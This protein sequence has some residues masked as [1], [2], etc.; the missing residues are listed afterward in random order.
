LSHPTGGVRWHV[1]LAGVFVFALA[2]RV[3]LAAIPLERDEGAYAYIAQHWLHGAIPY[4]DAFDHKPPGVLAAYAAILAPFGGNA[5]ASTIHWATQLYSLLTLWLIFWVGRRLA[6]E[7]VGVVAA[8]FAAAMLADQSVFGNAT[9]SEILLILPQTAALAAVLVARDRPAPAWALAA[10]AG[11]GAAIL[12]KQTAAVVA[13]AAFGLVV[14]VGPRRLTRG[15]LFAFG[16]AAP[17]V[18]AIAYFAA[19][20]ALRDLYDGTIGYNRAYASALSARAY[21]VYFSG[22]ARSV[23]MSF[24]PAAAL[25]LG[26]LVR[27]REPATAT[28][29]GS[30]VVFVWLLFSFFAICIGGRFYPHYWIAALPALALL[31]A[32]GLNAVVYAVPA[33]AATAVWIAGILLVPATAIARGPWYYDPRTSADVKARG[34]YGFN[35]FP[36]SPGVAEF[37][38]QRSGPED[39][40]FILGS[41]PQILYA[42]QRRS[43]SRYIYVYPMTESPGTEDLQSRVLEEVA[44][45]RPR[46]IVTVFVPTSIGTRQPWRLLDGIGDL[47]ARSYRLVG[48]L[49]LDLEHTAT[50]VADDDARAR[51]AARPYWY[52]GSSPWLLAVWERAPQD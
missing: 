43:A 38:V 1:A 6:D 46:L 44:R 39:A 40:V 45:A 42:A 23:A 24:W 34:L 5:G 15:A 14:P 20:G 9:N 32:L 28:R 22:F 8:F 2:I 4:R 16:F 51:W 7:R 49:P 52:R 12:F 18:A 36:E 29:D 26:L 37:V 48:L 47:L 19:H 30:R 33:R 17:V 21:R 3:P 50:M 11:L 10:G 41:E 25:A 31:A 35:P 27:R 13:V